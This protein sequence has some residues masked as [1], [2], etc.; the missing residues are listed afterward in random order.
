MNM[1]KY[2]IGLFFLSLKLMGYD[3][4]A[5]TP[6]AIY[7]SC[8]SDFADNSYQMSLGEQ[9]TA[10]SH[11]MNIG[12]NEVERLAMVVPV[13]PKPSMIN[14]LSCTKVQVNEIAE[15][16]DTI[17]QKINKALQPTAAGPGQTVWIY[18]QLT[19]QIS[20]A[21]DQGYYEFTITVVSSGSDKPLYMT[22][23]GITL[24]S[25]LVSPK[26]GASIGTFPFP[27]KQAL[28]PSDAP[29]YAVPAVPYTLPIVIT[30]NQ[31]TEQGKICFE[32]SANQVGEQELLYTV[33]F[34]FLPAPFIPHESKKQSAIK[35]I[36]ET[37][38]LEKNLPLSDLA[39]KIAKALNASA[40][41]T[42]E[43]W[44]KDICPVLSDLQVST[45]LASEIAD[46]MGLR[47][48]VMPASC[49]RA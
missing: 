27:A 6:G 2:I 49:S 34:T 31:K 47:E 24:Q 25:T 29:N 26:T 10:I 41:N 21:Q 38:L 42:A 14:S 43:T 20:S 19:P 23:G 15:T 35:N 32:Q 18:Y 37:Y 28:Q 22:A 13:G 3:G 40:Y 4:V 11:T 36:L 48:V 33:K 1:G 7:S 46:K 5:C 8:M 39:S 12:P 17:V 16:E 30:T 44:N 9:L 45:V